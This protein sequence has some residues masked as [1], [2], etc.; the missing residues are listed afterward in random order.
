MVLLQLREQPRK[1]EKMKYLILFWVT[2]DQ[3]HCC[4]MEIAHPKYNIIESVTVQS[5]HGWQQ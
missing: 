1:N 4:Y 3:N 2:V 5:A